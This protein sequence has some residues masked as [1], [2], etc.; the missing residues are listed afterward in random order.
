MS[1]KPLPAALSPESVRF[2]TRLRELKDQ[3]GVS[4]A[5]LARQTA[6]S[7]SSWERCLNGSALPPRQAVEALCRFLG[8]PAG[9]VL[10]LW[11]LADLTWTAPPPHQRDTDAH[12]TPG[13]RHRDG[14]PHPRAS[15][16]DGLSHSRPSHPDRR[17]LRRPNHRD[18]RPLPA[19]PTRSRPARPVTCP[20]RAAE[21]PGSAPRH[22]RRPPG[23]A[24]GCGRWC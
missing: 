18:R 13:A 3:A 20:H 23:A 11:E 22:G 21:P 2:V 16:H 10:A 17:P 24:T 7:K 1:W 5:V 9:P 6:Y 15:H 8:Q 19:A 14:L 12:R 4:L